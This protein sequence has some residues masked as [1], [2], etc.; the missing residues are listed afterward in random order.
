MVLLWCDSKS[1]AGL[2]RLWHAILFTILYILQFAC[3]AHNICDAELRPLEFSA[4][5]AANIRDRAHT[6]DRIMQQIEP[7]P[8]EFSAHN[9]ANT[10][11]RAHAVDRIQ[12]R[13]DKYQSK[14][15]ISHPILQ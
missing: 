12:D 11:D 7:R 14:S 13:A 8:L 1:V 3:T 9:A 5:N 4:H 10:R 15:R 2:Q 6:V